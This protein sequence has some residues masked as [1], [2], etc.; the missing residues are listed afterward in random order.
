MAL[1]LDEEGTDQAV[2]TVRLI[3]TSTVYIYLKGICREQN[4]VQLILTF[5][6]LLANIDD[7][8]LIFPTNW[9]FHHSADYIFIS[10]RIIEPTLKI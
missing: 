2:W 3:W 1:K 6:T 4:V 10:Y 7:I 8:F 5:T 9:A